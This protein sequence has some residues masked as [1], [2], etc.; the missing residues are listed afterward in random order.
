MPTGESGTGSAAP[1][2]AEARERRPTRELLLRLQDLEAPRESYVYDVAGYR[3][4]SDSSLPEL[5]SY[6]NGE[7]KPAY[8]PANGA[9]APKPHSAA[10]VHRGL[11]WL[12]ERWLAVQ[13]W[14]GTGGYWLAVA[15]AGLFWVAPDGC[16]LAHLARDPDAV[17]STIRQTILGPALIVAFA[18]Q[19][20]WSLHA[21]AVVFQ[22]RAVLFVGE[23]GGGKSTLATLLA[24]E[25]SE[26]GAGWRPLADDIL[27]V[28]LASGGMEA[29]PRYPQLK[30]P[31]DRQPSDGAP[32]R[33]PVAAV[34][35]LVDPV[36][37]LASV[38]VNPVGGSE[39]A[40]ALVR[41]TVAA[42]LFGPDLLTR[43]MTFCGATA[44]QLPIRDLVYPRERGALP[45]V[46][47][48]LLADLG[49]P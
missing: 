24:G 4:V 35:R 48:A 30:L 26:A 12:D 39:A 41:H 45:L 14:S 44:A 9:P 23:T 1:R 47:D 6:R 5:A 18:L 22:D 46:R 27:P 15:E 34:Y 29:L 38:E 11:G 7:P 20:T 16:T 43:H 31:P 3:L 49:G 19:D 37:G 28:E 42:R 33:L 25:V 17:P 2:T 13:C 8:P 32:E 36:P 21:S 10:M 40:L